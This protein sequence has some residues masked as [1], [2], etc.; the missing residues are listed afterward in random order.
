MEFTIKKR[1]QKYNYFKEGNFDFSLLKKSFL[2]GE[3]GQGKVYR[4]CDTTHSR[5]NE[6]IAVKKFYLEKKTSKFLETPFLSKAFT[7]S[8]FIE[9]ASSKLINEL[10]LQNISQNFILNYDWSYKERSGVCDEIF[11]YVSFHYNELIDSSELYTD[12]VQ[13]KHTLNEFYNAYFQIIVG[14]Y[15]LQTYFGMTHLDLHSDNIIVKKVTK[16][17]CWKYIINDD[18]YYL[19]NLGYIFLINDFGHAFVPKYFKSLFIREDYRNTKI[20]KIFDIQHLFRSTKNISTSSSTFKN[21]IKIDFIKN[22]KNNVMSFSGAIRSIW[23][24]KYKKP[25]G[26]VIKTFDTNISLDTKTIPKELKPLIKN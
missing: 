13:K 15:T 21:I 16:G 19:P 12:W 9:L 10:I 4:M 14:I 23:Q 5:K 1:K 17:G 2:L 20:T 25:F 24:K 26:K 8:N 3:G 6:C 18:I 22:V 7:H 11:P